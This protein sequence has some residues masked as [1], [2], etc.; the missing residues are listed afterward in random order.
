MPFTVAN[1]NNILNKLLRATD[2]T[3]PSTVYVSLHT[4]DPGDNGANEVTGGTYARQSCA[5]D[6]A[7]TNHT[8]NTAAINFTLMPAIASPSYITHFGLWSLASGGVFQGGG[9]MTAN[10]ETNA[11]DTYQIAAGDLDVTLT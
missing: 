3:P 2:F 6:A 9:T 4:G 11:G 10:K 1:R 8:Q 7:A 5:F